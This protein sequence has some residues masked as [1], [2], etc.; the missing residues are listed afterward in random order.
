ME[1]NQVAAP[2]QVNDSRAEQELI[3][4][5]AE[6]REAAPPVPSPVRFTPFALSPE[7]P[8]KVAE[9]EAEIAERA[10]RRRRAEIQQRYTDLVQSAGERYRECTLESYRCTTPQQRK[11]VDLVRE[12]LTADSSDNVILY[13]PVG[14]G[15][16]HIAFAI[17]RVAVRRNKT[18]AWINGQ[19]WFGLVR[20]AM[21]TS[22]TEASIIAELVRPDVLCLSDPTPPIG[23]LTPHQATMLYRLVDARYSRGIPT[24][25]TINV[26]DDS[27]A[28]KSMG[29][30]TWDRLCHG[31]WRIHC[32]WQTFRKPLKEV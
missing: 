27:E 12:Y 11:A 32:N 10:E 25:C 6:N 19:K 18:V 23:G 7:P 28:D 17:C 29:E 20:D 31:A 26:N 3:A 9:R 16:D 22:R 30:A 5:V 15:K 8:E 14:T 24:I 1:T 21:D 13:G 4:Y 2:D